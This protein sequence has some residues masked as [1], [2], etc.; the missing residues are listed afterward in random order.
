MDAPVYKNLINGE[1]IAAAT[2]KTFE[3]SNPANPREVLGIFPS[4]GEAEVR[5]AIDAA[6]AALPGWRN[7]SPLARGAI[8][9][10]AAH[11]LESRVDMVARDL[12]LEEGKTI[13][14]A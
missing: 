4:S 12:T 8:L 2:G 11:L 10:K 14:E 6:Q 3:D 1:W 5:R 9:L 7:T 13:G